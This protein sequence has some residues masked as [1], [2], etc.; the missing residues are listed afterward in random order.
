M[1]VCIRKRWL[2]KWFGVGACSILGVAWILNVFRNA[3]WAGNRWA[4]GCGNGL[5]GGGRFS[6]DDAY[7]PVGWHVWRSDDHFSWWP[8]LFHDSR[9]TFVH[10]PIWML[11]TATTLGTIWLWRSDGRIKTG[12]AKC[13]YDL[14]GNVSGVC[15]ECGLAVGC[16]QSHPYPRQDLNL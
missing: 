8:E 4:F 9:L 16:E 14:T 10:M 1:K 2:F 5:L 15:P 7:R 13:G 3:Y 11:L 6:Y 12:C